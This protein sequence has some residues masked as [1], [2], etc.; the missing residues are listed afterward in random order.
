MNIYSIYDRVAGVYSEP[1]LE[2]N[3][4]LAVRRFQYCLSQ[5]PMIKLDC[6][7]FRIGVFD[8]L[9]GVIQACE[10]PEFIKRYEEVD[11]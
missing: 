10:R 7:L 4:A 2:K 5:S 9:A 1:F 8:E 3:D 11:N 6:D